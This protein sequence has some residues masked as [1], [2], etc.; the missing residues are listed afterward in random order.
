MN[1]QISRAQAE[2]ERLEAARAEREGEILSIRG[3]SRELA[4]E[5][6]RLTSSVHKDEIAR[7]EQRLRIEQL[8]IKAVEEL[9][10]DV[11]TLLSEY[12]PTN[13]VPTFV[14]NEQGEFVP[15]ELI[16]YRREQQEKRLAQAERSLTLLG[17]INPLALEEYTSLRRASSLSS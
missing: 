3:A 12:G 2:R 16:P 8:E 11:A 17:K 13:D 4:T 15:G 10:V 1:H 9:G 6:E 7:A 5:L 14:E